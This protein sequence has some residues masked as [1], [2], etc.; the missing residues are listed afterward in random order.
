MV[1]S[2]GTPEHRFVAAGLRALA[3]ARRSEFEGRML[4]ILDPVL[5]RHPLS[6]GGHCSASPRHSCWWCRSPHCIRISERRSNR[7]A[8]WHGSQRSKGAKAAN[9]FPESF[10]VNIAPATPARHSIRTSSASIRKTRDTVLV[11][12]RPIAN[13]YSAFATGVESVASARATTA[14]DAKAATVQGC[15]NVRFGLPAS[16]RHRTRMLTFESGSS[17]IDVMTFQ[18]PALLECHDHRVVKFQYQ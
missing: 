7:P 5:D 15:D 13:P 9:D 11:L 17:I 3:M 10:K 18:W 1:R 12:R 6:K 14:A 16:T 8:R 4:S 2:L